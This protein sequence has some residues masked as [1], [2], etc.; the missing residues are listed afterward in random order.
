MCIPVKTSYKHIEKQPWL[1]DEWITLPLKISDLRR[2]A[3]L[4]ITAWY[5]ESSQGGDVPVCGANISL[6]DKYG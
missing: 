4:A 1:W 3:Q 6:F 5:I 2:N